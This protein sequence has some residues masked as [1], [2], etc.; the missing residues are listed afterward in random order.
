MNLR[1]CGWMVLVCASAASAGIVGVG[2]SVVHIQAPASAEPNALTSTWIHAWNEKQ[3]VVLEH[4]LVV[5]AAQPGTYQYET[6]LSPAAI[7]SGTVVNSHYIH[8]DTPGE[9]ELILSGWVTFDAPI[10]GVIAAGDNPGWNLLESTDFLGAPGTLY[11]GGLKH[12]G[13]ELPNGIDTFTISQDRMTLIIDQFRVV[14]PGDHVR[15][16]TETVPAPGAMTLAGLGGLLA[17]GR[18]RR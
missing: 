7:M 13:L 10:L 15:V 14:K 16:I 11:P 1:A 2:G 8:F 3:G 6:D 4:S 18:R 17:L 5:N 12:R 9:D